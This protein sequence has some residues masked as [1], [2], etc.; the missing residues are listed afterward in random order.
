MN[1][2]VIERNNQ[3]ES[4][5]ISERRLPRLYIYIYIY[6]LDREGGVPKFHSINFVI[7]FI[8]G[9]N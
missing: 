7:P 8:D 5:K 9:N 3:E 1:N 4:T 2:P 6:I